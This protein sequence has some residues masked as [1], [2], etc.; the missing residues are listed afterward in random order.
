MWDVSDPSHPAPIGN[1]LT[2]PTNYVYSVAFRPD[3]RT[4]A[5]ASTDGSVWLWD[6]TVPTTPQVAAV[7]AGSTDAAFAVTW[8]P[9]GRQLAVGSADRTVRFWATDPDDAIAQICRGSG[10]PMNQREWD[11]LAPGVPYHDGCAMDG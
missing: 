4:L 5:A 3:G 8:S 6:L 7:L 11:Q 2:G 1:P 10:V 9:D